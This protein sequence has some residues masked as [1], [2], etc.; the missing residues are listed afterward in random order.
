MYEEPKME[1]LTT[2]LPPVEVA[3][4]DIL[5]EAGFYPSRAEFIRSA[6]RDT[7]DVHR[8]YIEKKMETVMS[9]SKDDANDLKASMDI[10][11]IGV[12]L[13][14]KE[15]LEKAIEQGKKLKIHVVGMLKLKEDVTPEH[16]E[17]AVDRAKV[18]GVLR[19][20][21]EV[22]KALQSKTEST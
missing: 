18:Y 1:K 7:L 19:A 5:V 8:D 10:F 6:I 13:L 2:N 20:S 4:I 14:G 12:R 17:K 3:R 16:I 11:V 9:L 21:S 15:E 22:K